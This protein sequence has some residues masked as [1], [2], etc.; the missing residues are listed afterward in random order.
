MSFRIRPIILSYEAVPSIDYVPALSHALFGESGVAKWCHAYGFD[1]DWQLI[2]RHAYT[3]PDYRTAYNPWYD[4]W[5]FL[6]LP[7]EDWALALLVDWQEREAAGWGGTPLA[8]AGKFTADRLLSG[9]TPDALAD[10]WLAEGILCH[11]VGHVI[12]YGHDTTRE[13]NIMGVGMWRY[14]NCG[15]SQAMI[16]TAAAATARN[17]EVALEPARLM[18][19][20]NV[21][22]YALPEPCPRT[23]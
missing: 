22:A 16:D 14:P 8:I 2:E 11:E 23:P 1:L 7:P 4:V 20:L 6:A 12:G 13:N 5:K 15:P 21:R 3:G 17:T 19:L 18:G 10:D 9:G